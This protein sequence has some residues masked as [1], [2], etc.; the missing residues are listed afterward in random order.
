MPRKQHACHKGPFKRAR[1]RR[2]HRLERLVNRCKPFRRLAT[3][4]DKRAANYRAMWLIGATILWLNFA[5][6]A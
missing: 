5:N 1:Y 6:T 4:D 2:R 3:R